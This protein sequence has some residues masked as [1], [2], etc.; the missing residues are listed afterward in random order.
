M[1]VKG[2]KPPSVWSCGGEEGR[3]GD[4]CAARTGSLQTGRIG[5]RHARKQFPHCC[6]H[7]KSSP[8]AFALGLHRLAGLLML[9]LIEQIEKLHDWIF[10]FFPWGL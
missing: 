10:F 6:N 3:A 7:V 8:T 5:T 2:A 1:T 4:G 9:P